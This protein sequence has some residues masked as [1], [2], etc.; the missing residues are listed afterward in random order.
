MS[1]RVQAEIRTSF[2]ELYRVMSQR[3]E[4]RWMMLRIKR[5]AEPWVSAIRSLAGKQNLGRRR[6]KKVGA[7]NALEKVM[8][9][10]HW[11]SFGVW[12]GGKRNQNL[13]HITDHCTSVIIRSVP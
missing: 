5:M 11:V 2:E 10:N 7:L 9:R 3:E 6:R 1:S 12:H 13:A 4:F 8:Q